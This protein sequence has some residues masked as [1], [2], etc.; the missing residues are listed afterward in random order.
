MEHRDRD[1]PIALCFL[2][3]LTWE[4]FYIL[5]LFTTKENELLNKVMICVNMLIVFGCAGVADLILQIYRRHNELTNAL[6]LVCFNTVCFIIGGIGKLVVTG[7]MISKAST[8]PNTPL[9]ICISV[10]PVLV[11]ITGIVYWYQNKKY[12]ESHPPPRFNADIRY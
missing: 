1:R 7:F 5:V 3:L 6:A 9:F 10:E 8:V 2:I 4:I 11:C 12:K